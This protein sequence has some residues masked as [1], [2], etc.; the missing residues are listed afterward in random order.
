MLSSK[1]TKPYILTGGIFISLF[2]VIVI[3]ISHSSASAQGLDLPSVASLPDR[4]LPDLLVGI[5]NGFLGLLGV[6]A[7]GVLIYGGYVWMT[8]GGI[9]QRIALAKRILL[10]AVIGFIIILTSWAIVNYIINGAAGGGPGGPGPGPGPGPLPGASNFVV[11]WI[12]PK[13]GATDVPLCRIVQAGFSTNIDTSTI[14]AANVRIR[15][16]CT[17]DPQCTSTDQ[18]TGL[19]TSLGTCG[20]DNYCTIDVS[21]SYSASGNITAFYPANEWNENTTYQIFFSNSILNS[22]GSST[23]GP[24]YVFFFTT[25]TT[26]DVTPPRVIMTDPSSM[27]VQSN[28]CLLWPIAAQF[29]EPMDAISLSDSATASSTDNVG[30][31]QY[32]ALEI[33]PLLTKDGANDLSFNHYVPNPDRLFAKPAKA[34]E[35]FMTYSLVLRADVIKDACGNTLDGNSNGAAEGTP[36]DD[37]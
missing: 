11:K 36:A 19:V 27:S 33:S 29:S 26:T 14:N 21:G 4:P 23:L 35:E 28:I 2:F 8:S 25:G 16:A 3:V 17:A 9:S 18:D 22:S 37:Y 20:G 12:D 1:K 15:Q 13:D 10:S 6:I 5:I 31:D 30:F 32:A 7:L 34:M 24:P